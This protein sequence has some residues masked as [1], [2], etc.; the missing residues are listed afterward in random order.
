MRKNTK[1]IVFLFGLFF[2]CIATVVSQTLLKPELQFSS[3]CDDGTVKDFEVVFKYTTTAFNNDNQFTIELSDAS[4]GW[5][6]PINVGTVTTE[7]SSFSF[8]RTF[9]LP[10]NTFG[11]NY[12]IRLVATSP[13]MISPDSDAFEAYKII[14]G[15]LI[16]NDYDDVVLC[17]GESTEI[18]LN[19]NQEGAYQWYR[20]NAL[21]TTTTKPKLEVSE[22]G[23]Y[24]VKVDYGACGYKNSTLIEVVAFSNTDAQIKGA[25][26]VEI[27]GGDTHTF[28]AN[29]NDTSYTYSWYLDGTLVLSSNQ[30]TYTTPNAGQFGTYYLEIDTGNCQTTSD[31]VELKQ[32]SDPGFTVNTSGVLTSIMLPGETKELCITHN[33]SSAKVQWYKDATALVAKKQLCMNATEAGEYFARVTQS[34]GTSCDAIVDSDKYTLVAVK[35]FNAIVRTETGYEACGSSTTK[36]AVVGVKAIGTDDNEY[37]LTAEQLEMLSYQWS[38]NGEIIT[39]ATENEYQVNSYAD[40]GMYTLGVRV[41]TVTGNSNGIDVKL[42]SVPEVSASSISNSLCAEGSITYTIDN[43]MSG[44]NYQWIKNGVEDVTP[45]NPQTLEVTEEGEYVLRYSGFGCDNELAP[46]VVVPFDDSAVTI[47]PSEIVVLEAG[48]SAIIVAEGG[49]TYEWYEGEGISGNLLS[50]TEALTVT[51]LGFYTVL[52]KV[53]DCSVE[54]T[55]EVVEPDGQVIVPNLVSPNQ[56][57]F[58]DTW[59]LSNS[60][61]YQ[62]N[63]EVILYNS[64]G[65]EILKTTD[66]KNDWPTDELGNQKIFYYKII[67]DDRLIKAGTISV[68][69]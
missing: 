26:T 59:K 49:E 67:K 45:V 63:V 57:G 6:T 64:N 3:A 19:T 9:Q 37:D 13:A 35:S 2:S 36:L 55:I 33:A 68:L 46:I 32:K 69:D 15:N 65:K 52:V 24:Q 22:S 54:R 28:E 61:A 41:G 53:G 7:N 18:T 50:T 4:G 38:K 29:V 40:N 44:Y 5:S 27:C 14:N 23:N 11:T 51:T 39:A 1:N 34:T 21:I 58:N 60:Y 20:D 43:M 56:D 48:S 16:L 17:D 8:S 47:T 12:K 30:S 10:E 25:S 42:V 62:T 66:Y 31:N